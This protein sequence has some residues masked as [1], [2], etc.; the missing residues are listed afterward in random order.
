MSQADQTLSHNISE[1]C[2]TFKQLSDLAPQ[3]ERAATLIGDALTSDRKLLACGNGG[4]AADA[5]HMSTE[6]VC[7]FMQ[8]RRPYPAVSLASHGGDLTAIGNDYDYSQVFERQVEAFGQA[9]DVLLAISSSGQS[10]NVLLAIQAA[11]RR[12]VHTIAL[13]GKD[14][15][16]TKGE[17]D[18]ELIVPG[19]VTARIQEAQKLLIHTIC[20]LVEP[21]LA[22]E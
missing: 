18:V 6:F 7:R 4:C 5:S 8:D 21:R 20:E 15:G 10:R 14:G 11:K 3:V 13:L 17:A 12:Q 19:T 9:G 2:Q 1:A 16:F 22:G